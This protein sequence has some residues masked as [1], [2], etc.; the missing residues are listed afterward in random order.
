MCT[1]TD[2]EGRLKN[3]FKMTNQE[4]ELF[5]QTGGGNGKIVFQ[6]SVRNK[7]LKGT[8]EI[9]LCDDHG[10]TFI[11]DIDDTIK[12]TEVTSSTQTLINTFSG[13]FKAVE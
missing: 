6:A 2:D 1:K 10:V 11:S 5:R 13:D 4:V 7:N 8:G 3:T 12:I 9:F